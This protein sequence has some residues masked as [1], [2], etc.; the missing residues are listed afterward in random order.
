MRD[1]INAPTYVVPV[2]G[3]T[4][5]VRAP[6]GS[7]LIFVSGVTARDE[8][9]NV[10]DLGDIAGQTR[11]VLRGLTTILAEAGASL[12]DVVKMTTYM[13]NMEDHAAMHAV[14][15]EFF[16]DHPP[17]SSTVEVSR[18]YHPDQLIEIDAIAAIPGDRDEPR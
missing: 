8:R 9:G 18:L 12:D 7:Q 1:V 16:G 13:R 14:R 4:Q 2:E 10:A 5:A 3:F 17:A 6:A 11:R 15:R